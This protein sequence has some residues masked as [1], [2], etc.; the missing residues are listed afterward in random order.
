MRWSVPLNNAFLANDDMLESYSLMVTTVHM[1]SKS[2]G[3]DIPVLLQNLYNSVQ[4]RQLD[5]NSTLEPLKS[6]QN[7]AMRSSLS[8][9]DYNRLN[10]LNV[11][12]GYISVTR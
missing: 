1:R 3:E 6:T 11:R 9:T 7:Q 8:L 2:S 12:T 10:W 4:Y 5:R